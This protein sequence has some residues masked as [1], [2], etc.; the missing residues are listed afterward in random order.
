MIAK[1][2][3]FPLREEFNRLRKE[4]KTIQ[5]PLFS[6]L[7]K[8]GQ[9]EFPPRFAFII[10]KKISDKATIRNKIKRR[11]SEAVLKF[12]PRT[13][14]GAEG[15]FFAKRAIAE[16]DFQKIASVVETTFGGAGFLSQ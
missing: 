3:R 8:D 12:L 16:A 15:V 4:G 2:N 13:I 11:F 6:F 10:S 9:A 7:Y 5:T 1:K 14:P